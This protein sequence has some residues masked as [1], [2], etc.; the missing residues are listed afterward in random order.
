MSY[1][2]LITCKPTAFVIGWQVQSGNIDNT[3]CSSG[4][5][6]IHGINP[7]AFS[8]TIQHLY[9]NYE[10]I[11]NHRKKDTVEL[12]SLRFVRDGTLL[13]I[14]QDNNRVLFFAPISIL[15]FAMPKLE[16]EWEKACRKEGIEIDEE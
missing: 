2:Y 13:S 8:R 1:K 12:H 6:V 16:K 11:D 5:M 4:N 7:M 9:K 10:C 3:Q 14:T 15:S